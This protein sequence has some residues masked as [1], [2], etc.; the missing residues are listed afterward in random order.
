MVIVTFPVPDASAFVI[1]GT[2]F[3]G[4]KIAVNV[5][6]GAAVLGDV[7]DPHAV[8]TNASGTI[9]ASARFISMTPSVELA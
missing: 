2:S 5:G 1:G 9:R 3:A 8:A 4:N 7:D 6:F